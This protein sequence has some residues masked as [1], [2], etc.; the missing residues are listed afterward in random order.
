[1]RSVCEERVDEVGGF[2]FE[3]G[4]DIEENLSR[5]GGEEGEECFRRKW[6]ELS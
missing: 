6:G 1:M 4:G 3:W 2:G 5:V